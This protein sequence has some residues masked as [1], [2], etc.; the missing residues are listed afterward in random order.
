MRTNIWKK[1]ISLFFISSFLLLRIVD[2]HTISHFSDDDDDL[3]SCELCEIISL[4]NEYTPVTNNT[5]DE[6][7]PKALHY[8]REFKT[9]FYYETSQ[10]CITLPQS[11][12]N[13]PPPSII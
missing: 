10:Y 7:E 4:S 12:H 9:A 1:S 6:L 2:V 11:I 13:K 8:F 3:I 5:F